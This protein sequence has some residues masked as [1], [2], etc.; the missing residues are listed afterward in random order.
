MLGSQPPEIPGRLSGDQRRRQ[1]IEVAIDLFSRRGFNGTTT[2]EIA[3]A[4]G[5]TEAIIFRHFATKRDL[6]S[7][8][9][10]TRC[11]SSESQGWI[12]GIQ[13]L[14]AADDDEG[15]FR[16][17]ISAIVGI[18]R[19]D[20]QFERVMLYAALEGHELATMYHKQFAIPVISLL[21]EYIARRQADGSL[22]AGNPGALIFSVAGMAKQYAT[23]VH[24]FGYNDAGFS[25]EEAIDT[26]TRILM[27]GICV[28]HK[29]KTPA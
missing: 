28:N 11:Q 29:D 25:D 18:V 9:L 8:I 10:D 4:A 24:M 7:A 23:H 5:V 1:L 3:A 15:V 20:T 17:V 26:F 13:D 27:N 21:H 12:A 22:R 6:Y 16:M 2:K 14:M 19:E